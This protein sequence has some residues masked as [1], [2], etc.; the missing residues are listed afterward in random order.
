VESADPDRDAKLDRIEYVTSRFP[1]QTFAFDKFGR[2]S[3]R[4]KHVSSGEVVVPGLY[5]GGA[6]ADHLVRMGGLGQPAAPSLGVAMRVLVA[7]DCGHAG[8]MLVPFCARLNTR[9][10]G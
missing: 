10:T 1:E 9:P 8:A 6:V 4:P 2:L 3:I 5:H 7:G